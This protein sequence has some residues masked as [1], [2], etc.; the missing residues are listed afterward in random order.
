MIGLYHM[1]E[2]DDNALQD[3][4]RSL[5]TLQPILTEDDDPLWDMSIRGEFPVF[6][7]INVRWIAKNVAEG[8]EGTTRFPNTLPRIPSVA[9][10]WSILAS[11]PNPNAAKLFL[12]HF[13]TTEGLMEEILIYPVARVDI[14]LP[15]AMDS[16]EKAQGGYGELIQMN[17][18]DFLDNRDQGVALWEEVLEEFGRA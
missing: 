6:L 4:L 9:N 5:L 7:P 11:P 14:P 1:L 12:E 18:V 10:P 15:D 2:Y 3:W 16:L 17:V 13:Y 8:I